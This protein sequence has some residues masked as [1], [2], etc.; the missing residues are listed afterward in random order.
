MIDGQRHPT[1][2]SYAS[3]PEGRMLPAADVALIAGCWPAAR[4]ERRVGG[5]HD[6]T[7]SAEPAPPRPL[8]MTIHDLRRGAL[9]GS[10]GTNTR[11]GPGLP[12]QGQTCHASC[13]TAS[14]GPR[15][16]TRPDL[17]MATA[18]RPGSSTSIYA[19]PQ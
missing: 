2:P 5:A 18:D 16:W 7:G 9:P 1:T 15:L 8:A 11:K 13:S 6:V 14:R 12:T 4:P 10:A 3:C 19:E 17:K